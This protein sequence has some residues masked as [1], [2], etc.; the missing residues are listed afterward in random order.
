M[1]FKEMKR[2]KK[3][4]CEPD[5]DAA[6]SDTLNACLAP[7]RKIGPVEETFRNP[8]ARRKRSHPD[9]AIF[10]CSK[11]LPVDRMT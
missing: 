3:L 8:E 2:Q 11:K 1:H 4:S 6:Q 7:A 10:V 9:T 5:I